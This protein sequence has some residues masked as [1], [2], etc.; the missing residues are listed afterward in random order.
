MK[1][2]YD[3]KNV[4]KNDH[5][6][7][8]SITNIEPDKIITRSYSQEDL[9]TNIKFSEMVYLL[10]KGELP[11]PNETRMFNHILVSFCD[12]GVTP[13]STQTSRLIIS[14]GASLNVALAGG[15]LSFGKKHAGA[16]EDAMDL[17]Q[18]TINETIKSMN[19]DKDENFSIDDLLNDDDLIEKIANELVDNHFLNSKKM[20]G[21]GHRFHS[22]DPRGGKIME[23]AKKEECLGVHSKLALAIEKILIEKKNI[24]INVDGAN[25]AVLSDMGFSSFLGFGIFMIGRLPGLLAHVTEEITEEEAFRKFCHIEDIVYN[26][27][28]EEPLGD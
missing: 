4:H 17:F 2:E 28:E 13:P 7:K 1:K 24:Y 8:T 20:P 9:I 23:L 27:P 26:G 21:F 10:L 11:E 25:G 15:L 18:N 22:K 3:S 6:I 12:H 19:D 5:L 16:I 14:S